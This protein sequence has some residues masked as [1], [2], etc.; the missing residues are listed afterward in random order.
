MS[1]PASLIPDEALFFIVD[2]HAR[3][4]DVIVFLYE[5]PSTRTVQHFN[6]VN[7]HLKG[8]VR[9]GQMVI[10]TPP[11]PS[12]CAKWEAVMM[13][14]AARVDAELASATERERKALAQH[15]AF[16]NSAA[17]YSGTLYGWSNTYFDQKKKHVERILKNIEELYV[18]TYKQTGSLNQNGFFTRRRALFLQL[19]QTINGMLETKMFGYDV[20]PNR[21]RAE[22]GLSSKATVHQWKVQGGANNVPAF[23][24][25]YQRLAIAS[26]NFS[27]L[28]YVAIALDVG[29]S[30]T[31]IKAACTAAP[32]SVHCRKTQHAETGRAIG[33]IGGG[34]AGGA[35]AAYGVC[36]L[37][38]GLPSAGSSFLWCSIVAGASGGYAGS[39]V[40]GKA[41]ETIG[42]K[43]YSSSESR[44]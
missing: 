27:R 9:P 7:A 21:M 37:V 13:E 42:D 32:G 3:V 5:H 1:N 29:S 22:L 11:E 12:A 2:Q 36:S 8:W 39:K 28:G 33:S 15:Y 40:M 35:L 43:I 44:R 19:D 23:A 30:V 31:N 17:G 4:D 26:K 24:S 10:I 25:N 6:E 18:Q 34:A 38:F 14:A 20:S 41:G 16:L